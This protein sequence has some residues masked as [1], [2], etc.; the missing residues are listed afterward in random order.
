MSS[1]TVEIS[2][3][4]NLP[5]YTIYSKPVYKGHKNLSRKIRKKS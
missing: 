5:V 3:I 4:E 1:G 2:G